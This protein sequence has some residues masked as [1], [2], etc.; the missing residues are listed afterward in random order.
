MAE[1]RRRRSSAWEDTGNEIESLP[2]GTKKVAKKKP[3]KKR[4]LTKA[5]AHAAAHAPETLG[6]TTSMYVSKLVGSAQRDTGDLTIATLKDAGKLIIGIPCPSFSFE[7]MV[8]NTVIPLEKVMQIY[9]VRGIGKSGLA[10]EIMRIFRK[11]KGIG[12]LL[13][14]ETKFN[15][16]WASSIIGWDD[17]GCLGVIPCDAIDEWQSHLQK[18][19]KY[20]KRIMTGDSKTLGAGRIFPFLAIVDSIMGKTMKE[21]QAKI[22]EVGHAGRGFPIEAMSITRFVQSFSG[23]LRR[24]PFMLICINHLKVKGGDTGPPVE[25]RSGGQTIDFQGSFELKIKRTGRIRSA[26][27]DGNKLTIKAE[28]NSYGE[29]NRQIPVNCIWWNEEYEDPVEGL[30]S[31]QQTR[32][33]WHGSTVQLI[34]DNCDAKKGEVWTNAKEVTGLVRDSVTKAHSRLLGV[35]KKKD[36]VDYHVL[37]ARIA[38]NPLMMRELRN[39]FGI[40]RRKVFNNDSDYQDQILAL[41][42]K[43]DTGGT[44]RGKEETPTRSG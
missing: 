18:S 13:E 4:K 14:H 7:Y 1:H 20:I 28:K 36:A 17:L 11:H 23:K 39:M 9:G 5:Q 34:L 31:R 37:G 30:V 29:D 15:S 16:E 21:T 32:F 25:T 33:D 10:F 12:V 43:I 3:A 8:C 41:K 40:T 38:R 44:S 19:M 26:R 35:P 24:W 42:K 27:V 6:K 2:S 22:E